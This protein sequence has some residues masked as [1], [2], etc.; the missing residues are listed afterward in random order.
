MA[1]SGTALL[2]YLRVEVHTALQATTDE[3]QQNNQ[4]HYVTP[5]TVTTEHLE[6]CLGKFDNKMLKRIRI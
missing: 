4:T 6:H 3:V 1:C 5:S 2:F